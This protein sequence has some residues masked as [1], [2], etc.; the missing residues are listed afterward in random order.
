MQCGWVSRC[1]S[2]H[3]HKSGFHLQLFEVRAFPLANRHVVSPQYL[4]MHTSH[5]QLHEFLQHLQLFAMR[6]FPIG[7]ESC[8]RCRELSPSLFATSTKAGSSKLFRASLKIK[9][10]YCLSSALPTCTEKNR[11]G[12]DGDKKIGKGKIFTWELIAGAPGNPHRSLA[13]VAPQLN[14]TIPSQVRHRNVQTLRVNKHA[15]FLLLHEFRW[16]F[17]HHFC[18]HVKRRASSVGLNSIQLCVVLLHVFSIT[19]S[20]QSPLPWKTDEI[21]FTRCRSFLAHKEEVD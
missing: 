13:N 8:C 4:S 15:M 5:K 3:I 7:S 12:W 6:A 2:I 19:H 21:C 9:L 20:T 11:F 18:R 14:A 16:S 17:Q 10:F 1:L